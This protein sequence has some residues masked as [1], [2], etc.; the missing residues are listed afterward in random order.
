MH[1]IERFETVAGAVGLIA[2]R[3]EQI[4]KEL[5]VELVVFHDQDGF[6][7][8]APSQMSEPGH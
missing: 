1:E 6:C 7:H 2:V 8:P 5:H 3:L 4:A